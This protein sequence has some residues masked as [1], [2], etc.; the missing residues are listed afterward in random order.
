M[1]FKVIQGHRFWYQSKAHID[2]QLVINTNFPPVLHRF[3]PLLRLPPPPPTEGFSWDD[4]RKIFRG[5]QEMFGGQ[6]T[7]RHRNIAENLNR[8]SRAH[9]RTDRQTTDGRAIACSEKLHVQTSQNFPY[10]LTVAV[11]RAPLTTMQ[12]CNVLWVWWM[13]SCLHIVGHAARG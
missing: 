8:L 7:K 2:F 5:C 12:L 1:P 13:T 4:L 9:E 11:A 10:T 6:V 3:L